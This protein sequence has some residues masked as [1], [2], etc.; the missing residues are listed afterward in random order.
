MV[1]EEAE[2]F[3]QCSKDV[4]RQ[5]RHVSHM[6][7]LTERGLESGFDLIYC[8]LYSEFDVFQT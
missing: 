8:L 5:L 2:R 6:G 3:N 4:S 1:L 7:R